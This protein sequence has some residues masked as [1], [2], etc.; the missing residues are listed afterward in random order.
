MFLSTG[1]DVPE[2]PWSQSLTGTSLESLFESPP[3]VH[4][5]DLQVSQIQTSP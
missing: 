1:R 2:V 5:E 3:P 4:K